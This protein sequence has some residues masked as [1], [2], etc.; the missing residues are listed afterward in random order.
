M[1]KTTWKKIMSLVLV[2]ALV[3]GCLQLNAK[4]V[5]ANVEDT[6]TIIPGDQG[7]NPSGQYQ[8]TG[9]EETNE[10]T[11]WNDTDVVLVVDLSTSM[12]EGNRLAQVKAAA[13][14]FVNGLLTNGNDKISIGIVSYGTKANVVSGLTKSISELNT[15]ING[16]T[17]SDCSGEHV[18]G[19]LQIDGDN[20][21]TNI[22]DGIKKAEGLFKNNDHEKV[23]VILSDGEPTIATDANG[24]EVLNQ[25]GYYCYYSEK[26]GLLTK[27]EADKAKASGITVYSILFGETSANAQTVMRDYVASEGKYYLSSANAAAIDSVYST[28]AQSIQ[29]EIVNVK[30]GYIIANLA[31]FIAYDEAATNNTSIE[32]VKDESGKVI[33]IKWNIGELGDTTLPSPSIK[34]NVTATADELIAAGFQ[35]RTNEAGQ[36]VISVPVTALTNLYYTTSKGD[37]G[38]F[39]VEKFITADFVINQDIVPYTVNYTLDGQA[40]G[41]P[42][43]GYAYVGD[44]IPVNT[45][46]L[47]NDAKYTISYPTDKIAKANSDN[48]LTVAATTNKATVNFYDIDVEATE[49]NEENKAVVEKLVKTIT[50]D[51]GNAITDTEAVAELRK[52]YEKRVTS[53]SA[54]TFTWNENEPWKNAQG[55]V[56]ALG[57]ASQASYAFFANYG[58]TATSY[59]HVIF[60]D[61]DGTIFVDGWFKTGDTVDDYPM[62]PQKAY[63]EAQYSKYEFI[64]WYD[65][66][67]KKGDFSDVYTVVDDVVYTATYEKVLKQYDVKYVYGNDT[68]ET[69]TVDYGTKVTDAVADI[70]D[71][72]ET[73]AKAAATALTNAEDNNKDVYSF[74]GWDKTFTDEVVKADVVIAAQISATALK[75]YTVKYYC[76][77]GN[78]IVY[79]EGKDQAVKAGDKL[80]MITPDE[81]KDGFIFDNDWYEK[82]GVTV[83]GG[84]DIFQDLDIVFVY[85]PIETG[86]FTFF[87]YEETVAANEQLEKIDFTE[88]TID[89][90]AAPAG[91][92][93]ADTA[94]VDYTFNEWVTFITYAD[95]LERTKVEVVVSDDVEREVQLSDVIRPNAAAGTKTEDGEWI[96]F[97]EYMEKYFAIENRDFFPT[98]SE[99]E[100]KNDPV[101][102]PPT[103]IIIPIIT[104]TPEEPT[105]IPT[106]EPTPE[107]TA[108]PTPVEEEP[109]VVEEPETPEGDVVEDLEPIDTPQS[110]PEEEELDVE[111]IDTPQGDL[112][113]TGVAPSAVFFGIGAAC[114]VFG[115]AI[116]LKLRR[117]EEM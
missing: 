80:A 84:M 96:T 107:P 75:D 101:I 34:F 3:I 2:A 103:N 48:E 13:T 98:Y 99:K 87:K 86:A 12:G 104:E 95:M 14:N 24:R 117:K 9:F 19:G 70:K 52:S 78:D 64:G 26:I 5:S 11:Q 51:Y 25:R 47:N 68:F 113:K 23:I 88:K 59:K 93:K 30:S 92:E 76:Q 39:P 67:N 97:A 18:T 83:F 38:P 82:S 85:R 66:D 50:V 15:K 28:I 60:K 44:E 90:I 115:G 61:D 65:E 56:V 109:I 73:K 29:E 79:L 91:P 71:S 94:T 54:I 77:M 7:R 1:K 8:L 72:A 43:T 36:T 22:Q 40:N 100:I 55:E 21:L 4:K 106:A 49:A 16:Q 46:Y 112:P 57:T 53:G 20:G 45:N 63:D 32:S 69:V 89:S 62:Q 27:A 6:V 114:V 58:D 74:T 110:A 31:N 37:F 42:V 35:T 17:T 111:P 41:T 33:A 108:E 102:T 105:P 116:V 81:V 10:I